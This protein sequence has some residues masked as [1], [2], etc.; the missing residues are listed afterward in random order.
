MAS[1]TYCRRT[2]PGVR[3]HASWRG[4]SRPARGT[5]TADAGMASHVRVPARQECARFPPGTGHEL[6]ATH[7]MPPSSFAADRG[8]TSGQTRTPRRGRARAGG[9][10]AGTHLRTSRRRSRQSHRSG[11]ACPRPGLRCPA[12]A[13]SRRSIRIAWARAGRAT[14]G[15]CGWSGTP[16]MEGLVPC[17]LPSAV[18]VQE[19]LAVVIVDVADPNVVDRLAEVFAV[20]LRPGQDRLGW[21]G[22]PRSA[23]SLERGAVCA[24]PTSSELAS[25]YI[26]T[27]GAPGP[28]WCR[29]SVAAP[30]K[31]RASRSLG[32]GMSDRPGPDVLVVSA[33]ASRAPGRQRPVHPAPAERA[34]DRA[35]RPHRGRWCRCPARVALLRF[36]SRNCRCEAAWTSGALRQSWPA[37]GCERAAGPRTARGAARWRT[38]RAHGRRGRR[39]S[40]SRRRS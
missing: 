11:R 36:R 8:P 24:R 38:G 10:R 6:R 14:H 26:S 2:R 39:G 13:A 7:P 34:P 28:V 22:Q 27:T 32:S 29:S 19:V 37:G 31:S 23:S 4:I 30:P 40:P 15:A 21:A 20:H 3:G 5:P 18:L 35:P 12:V 1:G 9:R 17:A 25:L 33:N 16:I